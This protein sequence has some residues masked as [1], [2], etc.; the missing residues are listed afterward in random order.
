MKIQNIIIVSMILMTLFSISLVSLISAEANITGTIDKFEY[1]TSN[2]M[3]PT[4]IKVSDSA[5]GSIYA[6]FY[7][8]AIGDGFVSTYEILNNGT[9]VKTLIDTFEFDTSFTVTPSAIKYSDNIYLVGYKG[10]GG[11]GF[12]KTINISDDGT[13]IGT[14][15]TFEIEETDLN[16]PNVFFID[17][18]N[19]LVGFTSSQTTVQGVLGTGNA[20]SNGTINRISRIVFNDTQANFVDSINVTSNV[21][22]VVYQAD[23]GGDN[24]GGHVQTISIF[25][26]GTAN[27]TIDLKI[28]DAGEGDHPSITYMGN[29]LYAIAYKGVGGVGRIATY[30]VF[31]NGSISDQLDVV[32]FGATDFPNGIKIA[33]N[34][35]GIV[36]K[37]GSGQGE[38]IIREIFN[39]GSINTQ[40]ISSFI[41]DPTIERSELLKFSNDIYIITYEGDAGDG[42]ITTVNVTVEICTENWIQNNS[43]C[44]ILDN[45]TIEYFDSNSCGTFDDLPANNGTIL[46]CDFCFEPFQCSLFDDSCGGGASTLNCLATETQNPSCCA[47]TNLTSDCFFQGNLSSFEFICG[48]LDLTLIVPQFPYVDFNVTFP[49]E[50]IFTQNNITVNI[51]DFKLNLT[52]P[53]G[54]T[55]EFDF[56]VDQFTQ[57]YKLNLLFIEEGDFPFRIFATSPF[58]NIPEITGTLIVRKPYFITFRAFEEKNNRFFGRS[59]I[60]AYKNKFAVLTAELGRTK[61]I[62]FDPILE[63]YITPLFF[64]TSFNTPLFSAPYDN[65]EAVLK[66]WETGNYGFRLIDARE[67][68]FDGIF[69]VPN[70]TDT[71]GLNAFVGEFTFNG[72]D[73]VVEVFFDEKDTNQY[74]WLFNIIFVIALVL[75][76][77]TS[78][79][80]F[81]VIP[82]HANISIL[83]G[84]GFTTMLILFR[85]FMFIWRGW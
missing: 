1:E 44:N 7:E 41:F 53:D 64:S 57:T 40:T 55:S 78:V 66:L 20:S 63:H 47:T 77:G 81:F 37:D 71:Y 9:I 29:D 43:A 24:F 52:S 39:N 13:I 65:G 30:N 5:G 85:V 79:F 2:G 15:D 19:S 58:D 69:V 31:A 75:I 6:V 8:G 45:Q 11:D 70:V 73:Q 72:T 34:L 60:G 10:A 49:M 50:L 84:L 61:K 48:V 18:A 54:N 42:F 35:L 56:V 17:Q 26:N 23:V 32:T 4:S 82:E 62:R 67:I 68:T 16:E 74:R 83:F 14:L 21:V 12:A 46:F 22:L 51:T 33:N 76:I 28:L 80:L 27:D 38:F 59:N 25:P 3:T 36:H